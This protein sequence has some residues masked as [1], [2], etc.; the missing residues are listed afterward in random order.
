MI[1]FAIA[2]IALIV[3]Q[4]KLFYSASIIIKQLFYPLKSY[5]YF[6]LILKMMPFP[7]N[8]NKTKNDSFIEFKAALWGY[9]YQ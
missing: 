1:V 6:I 9:K 4:N 3:L 7:V 5:K 8:D 2:N